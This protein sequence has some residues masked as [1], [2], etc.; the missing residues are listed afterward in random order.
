MRTT[1]LNLARVFAGSLF[2]LSVVAFLLLCDVEAAG[3]SPA[4]QDIP[5][6]VTY[7][8]N[9]E[10]IYI[11]NCNIRDTSDT[12]NCM[13]A[14]PDHLTPT[15]LNSYTYVSRGALKKLL[16]TCQQPTAK[17]LAAA[18]AFQQR[19]QDLYNANVKKAEQSPPP[20][21]QAQAAQAISQGSAGPL[22]GGS[23]EQRAMRRC[24][25]AGR[26]PASCTGNG[27]MGMFSNMLTSV[28][29]SQKPSGPDAGPN[30]AGVF[31]GAG[32]W[33][34]DFIDGGVL[35]NCSFLSPNQE[36]YSLKF[37]PSR[38][39]LIINTTPKPLNLT[40]HA[41]GTITGPGPVTID[42]VVAGGYTPGTSTPG[43]TETQQYNTTERMNAYEVPQ[44]SNAT[45]AGGGFY[46]VTT[47]HTT[48][49]YVPGQST[50]GYTNFVAKRTTCPAINLSSKGA[51]VGIQTMQTDLLKSMFGGDKGAPTP[52]G[53]R[54]H[55][56]FA[57]STGFSV[58]F[59]PESA[60]LG[61]GPDAA[62]AY[63]YSVVA[64]ASG[65]QIKI[66][67]SDHPLVL[68][69]KSDGA[70]EPTATGPYQVHGRIIIGQDQNDNFTFAPYEQTC[71]L[72]V[73]TPSSAI[74]SSG[75]T[76]A[77]MSAAIGS[78]GPGAAGPGASGS[79]PTGSGGAPAAG[80]GFST[81]QAPLGNATLSVVSGFAAQP[82]APNPLAGR[83]YLLL[84]FSYADSL[85]RAGVAV[86][87]GVS[88]YKYVATACGTR[89]PDC[90]KAN[91]AIKASVASAVRADASGSGNFPGVQ[92]GTYYL[93]I[94]AAYNNKPLIWGQPVQIHAGA[95]SIK[96][97]ANNATPL[98]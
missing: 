14:H 18:K 72:A 35:V 76:A 51:G 48:S 22:S 96:L 67:T 82:G 90:Q 43:H 55:G 11:E 69:F 6:G 75:G 30:M 93:L 70:L 97:D 77:P 88:P 34:L 83:P 32:N 15:G 49:T 23:P 95:N 7:I 21:T 26:L 89:Q 52:P 27:L 66:E 25:S 57:A 38:T 8:C 78:A 79:S 45:N 42:G 46:D 63:P 59:F 5:I 64:T 19:Q 36:A 74:P 31:Q 73:L 91:D 37:E 4:S 28:I 68:A 54:M 10:H 1:S 58:Q 12:A 20:V 86:P 47:T 41:D 9:G 84:R 87:A 81:P 60:I 24:V 98:N 44:N 40:F 39:A 65:A 50:T 62:R 85:A 61:C 53:I 33:R 92:P 16:P 2:F 94:S 56:I 29:G 17:Q 80:G 13:V 3:Q 71:N